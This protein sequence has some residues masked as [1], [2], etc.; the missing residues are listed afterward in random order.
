MPP[1][2]TWLMTLPVTAPEDS[3]ASAVNRRWT[4][5]RSQIASTD[6]ALT[7]CSDTSKYHYFPI[8][9]F[10]FFY[11]FIFYSISSPFVGAFAT[12]VGWET[13][14]T[15]TSMTAPPALALTTGNVLTPLTIILAYVSLD[16]LAS[17]ASTEWTTALLSPVRTEELVPV[18]NTYF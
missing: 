7:N 18:S 3:L 17:V 12:P 1:V 4:C 2:L 13:C 14:V 15:S 8:S 16:S 6:T 5:V 11:F 9:L 10:V